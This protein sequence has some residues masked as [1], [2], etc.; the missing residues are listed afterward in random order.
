MYEF[1]N[2][3]NARQYELK[4]ETSFPKQL[5]EDGITYPKQLKGEIKAPYLTAKPKTITVDELKTLQ[6]NILKGQTITIVDEHVIQAVLD[7]PIKISTPFKSSSLNEFMLNHI[8]N[9]DQYRFWEKSKD[10]NTITYYQHYH[11]KVF[12]KNSNAELIFYLNEDNEI[13][14]YRQT[15]LENIKELPV[16]ERI[17]DPMSAIE[18][19]YKNNALK[20]K[21]K[22]TDVETGYFTLKSQVLTPAWRVEIN[23]KQN[24]FVNA[25]DGKIIELNKDEK[26]IVE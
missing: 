1:F 7:Q 11:D 8:L 18:S 14:S 23:D 24:L 10:S 17:I 15:I 25:F 12:F 16:D 21:I 22:I 26:K 5:Q 2:L 9:S 19:L 13:F 20:P 3:R 4:T 6:A